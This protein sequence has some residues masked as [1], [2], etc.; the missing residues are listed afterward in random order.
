MTLLILNLPLP[1]TDKA[2]INAGDL[3]LSR[4]SRTL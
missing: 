4:S 1:K 3:K 2:C